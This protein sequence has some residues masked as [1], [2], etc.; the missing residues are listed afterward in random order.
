M[1]GAQISPELK[2]GLNSQLCLSASK[3]INLKRSLVL[4]GLLLSG[5]LVGGNSGIS[6]IPHS[7]TPNSLPSSSPVNQTRVPKTRPT[8]PFE[9]LIQGDS[10]TAG[11][12]N[13]TLFVASNAAEAARFTQLLNKTEVTKRIQ[14]IDFNSTY[15]VAV[16]RGQVGSSGYGIAIQ[17]ISTAAGTVQLTVSLTNPPSDRLVSTVIAYP[18]HIVLVPREKLNL[19]PGTNWSVSTSEGKLLVQTKYP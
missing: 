9:S 4:L 18:Y 12:E 2:F 3:M 19:T 15:I 8:I 11:L 16:F 6:N 10:Y 7:E 5:G 1:N 17:Q 13:P 14:T